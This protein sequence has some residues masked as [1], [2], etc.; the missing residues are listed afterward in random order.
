MSF[1]SFFY[2]LLF[3]D[4]FLREGGELAPDGTN[5][6]PNAHPLY[7]HPT[8]LA[9]AINLIAQHFQLF[10]ADEF[11]YD[12]VGV[13]SPTNTPGDGVSPDFPFFLRLRGYAQYFLLAL[14]SI[15]NY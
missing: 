8:F 2:L 4:F 11:F 1:D 9:Q 5:S 10:F 7:A 12:S 3:L 6:S 14:L 15:I 13:I